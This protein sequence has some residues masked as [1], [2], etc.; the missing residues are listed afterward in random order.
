MF[1]ETVGRM[2]LDGVLDP[3]EW[4]TGHGDGRTRPFSERLESGYGAW[5]SLTAAFAECDRVGKRRCVLA[6]DASQAWNEIIER[7]RKKPFGRGGNRVTYDQVV[8]STLGYLYSAEGLPW[9]MRE[10]KGLHR[11]MFGKGALRAA[12]WRPMAVRRRIGDGPVLPGPYAFG[13]VS[14]AFAGVACADSDNPT[15]PRAWVKAGNRADRLSPWFGKL[16]TWAS[17][18]CA[19]WPAVTKEDRFAG[20]FATTDINPVLVVGNTYDPATP[21]HGARAVNRLHRRTPGCW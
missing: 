4:T 10:I 19:G 16:W 15:G 9:L 13:R 8:G 11:A 17:S 14:D 2:I 1:P 5:Q 12:A 6:G 21:L 20:P 3:E 18:P 7:L